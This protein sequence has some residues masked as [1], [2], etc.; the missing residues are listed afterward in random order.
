MRRIQL[1]LDEALDQALAEEARRR[2]VAK[3]ALVRELLRQ[4]F[5]AHTEDPVDRVVG[6]G[7]GGPVEDIDAVLYG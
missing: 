6:K 5:P 7:D 4:G 3:A 1:H 2:G